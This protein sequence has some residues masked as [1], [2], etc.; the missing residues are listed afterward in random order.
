MCFIYI[1]VAPKVGNASSFNLEDEIATQ[2]TPEGGIPADVDVVNH[3][4]K[5]IPLPYIPLFSNHA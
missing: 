1:T 3:I 2:G 4:F 5:E